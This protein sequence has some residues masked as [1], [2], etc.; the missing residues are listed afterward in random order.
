[1]T[2]NARKG[3]TITKVVLTYYWDSNKSSLSAS[4]GT[5][6]GNAT[7][8]GINAQQ[9][10]ISS[11]NNAGVKVSAV[12]VYFEGDLNNPTVTLTG[13]ANAKS[14]GGLLT[15]SYL[16]GAMDT[17]TYTALTGA[18]FPEFE[19]FTQSGVTVERTSDTVVTISGTPTENTAITVPDAESS[20]KIVTWDSSIINDSGRSID[21]NNSYSDTANGI[22][23]T[24]SGE[25][26]LYRGDWSAYGDFT[27]N[28][29]T[30]AGKFTSIEIETS[31]RIRRGGN[32][33]IEGNILKWNGTPSNSVSLSGNSLDLGGVSGINFVIEMPV[34]ISTATLN[35]ADDN[36]VASLTIGENMIT[37]LTGFD[38]TYGTDD[39]HE[40]TTPSTT[41]GSYF[42]YVSVK[43]T[44]EDYT[45][46]AKAAFKI[47]ADQTVTP[48]VA[49]TLTY[50]GDYQDLASAATVTAG[51][52]AENAI[53]Y[54]LEGD[55]DL[56]VNAVPALKDAGTYKLYYK[57]AGNDDYNE[58]VG[59]EPI[60]VTIAKANLNPVA[61]NLPAAK[62][63]LTYNGN[64]QQ[65]VN[66]PANLPTGCT[67]MYGIP[68]TLDE[69]KIV[70]SNVGTDTIVD[71]SN[72]EEGQ[73]LLPVGPENNGFLFP[74]GY[75][76]KIGDTTYAHSTEN[77]YLWFGLL[78]MR[79][80]ILYDE[81]SEY[82]I[83][84][85]ALRVKSINTTSQIIEMEEI[86]TVNPLTWTDDISKV[87]GTDAGKYKVNY[88]I[89]GDTNH[90]DYVPTE[91]LS[92]TI[93]P[94]LLALPT[95]ADKAPT[96]ISGLSFCGSAQQLI[97]APIVNPDVGTMQY[98][99]M[100]KAAVVK[101]VNSNEITLESSDT[102]VI[103]A[104]NNYYS[105]LTAE[106][107]AAFITSIGGLKTNVSD[108]TGIGA[109]T[110]YVG[111]YVEAPNANY[112]SSPLGILPVAIDKAG[113]TPTVSIENWTYGEEPK[114][115]SVSGN[116][117]NETV[118]YKYKLNGA[119]DSTYNSEVPTVAG[120][121]VVKAEIAGTANYNAA[122]AE[123]EFTVAK[124]PLKITAD[125]A[126]K[127]YG[128][129]DPALTYTLEGTLVGEDTITGSLTREK[130]DNTGE[131]TIGQGTLTAGDNYAI[132]FVSDKFTV[133]PADFNVKANGYT[134][135][136]DG[137][138]HGIAASSDVEDAKVYYLVSDTEP[139]E[140]DFTEAD[141]T[142]SPK[143]K[144]AGT[145]KIWYCITAPNYS[146]VI[147]Y[148]TV[149][150]T[151]AAVAPTV[152]IANWTYGEKQGVPKIEGLPEGTDFSAKVT[153]Y[154]KGSDKALGAEPT[155]AG[156]YTVA[157]VIGESANYLGG[158]AKADFSIAKAAITPSVTLEGW[159]NGETANKPVVTGNAGNGTVKFEYKVKGAEDSTYSETVPTAVGTYVVKAS[160]DET[161]NYKAGSATAEFTIGHGHSYAEKWSYDESKHWRECTSA[162]GECDAQK[163]DVAE[164]TFTEWKVTK[165]ATCE[166]AGTESR[167]CTVCGKEETRPVAATGHMYGKPE[168]T[169]SADGKT[170]TATV[171]C[172]T[173][174]KFTVTEEAKITSEVKAAATC[175][176]N[177]V[178]TYTAKFK[179]ELFS[180]Q[181]QDVEDIPAT[182]HKFGTPEYAWSADGKT[183]TAAVICETDKK[184]TVTEEAKVTSAVKT[185]ATCDRNGVT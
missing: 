139:E 58:F 41:A 105:H 177:G 96:A 160:V 133:T 185:A 178:T 57:V 169:W 128:T 107:K 144:D 122:S 56:W 51:N 30:P 46:T 60:V 167:K 76:I 89:A 4:P 158:T 166:E 15:Q 9:V 19:T 117:E 119:D 10:T 55:G 145:Y 115:P 59:T 150:I 52:T 131:Y 5:F 24:K 151:K 17:V 153:Y 48:P 34:D 129:A 37:D 141:I 168:Y 159:K 16:P 135:D 8:S 50:T 12:T 38:I 106:Q 40:A 180:V 149:E 67:V 184:F 87:T 124:K 104:F 161:A 181:T 47:K 54:Q 147:S 49:N 44:N 118:T 175:D 69:S 130:G 125:K 163:T 78:D 111:Y 110:Y 80:K 26:D 74:I 77:P 85:N 120:T 68:G 134:G 95:E 35:L 75:S 65:L 3:E 108:I 109:G 31:S 137:K 90:N 140:A 27:L 154:K 121:Y 11:S 7:I 93:N 66:A 173:D 182:T 176:R 112:I 164:H 183:C 170:C 116:A 92:V 63:D 136:Y 179:T 28:F 88:K 6:D 174:K 132:E 100:S 23:L 2:I 102:D 81:G 33:T 43:D 84:G 13:G 91:P 114:T 21:S 156:E 142:V 94:L 152:S 36:S 29:T 99:V 146:T 83:S 126:G 73:I 103:S 143:Y 79:Y 162:E 64:A 14:S 62:T 127:V 157:A 39:S 61:E 22:T 148:Q 42:A 70:E 1:M 97:N 171:I 155:D 45:G 82:L 165:E 86:D 123:K 98:A 113:I 20:S 138:D 25:V 72:V 101:A 53:Q 71:I 18:A 32:W 172:E